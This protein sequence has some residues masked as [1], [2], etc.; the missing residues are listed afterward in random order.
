MTDQLL[1][2]EL[3]RDEG[4]RLQ[5]YRDSLGNWTIGYGHLEDPSDYVASET[6]AQ[7]DAT[8]AADIDSMTDRL[9]E[10]LPWIASLSPPRLR[11]L[12]NMAFN[13]GVH[14][15]LE[16]TNTLN[17]I[18]EGN[19]AQASANMLMSTWA[20]QVGDRAQRLAQQMRTGVEYV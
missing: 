11:V 19:Y 9:V 7:A 15:L 18:R 4:V 14:G 6:Q 16:F 3:H 17:L 12:Q 8:L 10:A 2:N 20:T 13:M 5:A 1:V